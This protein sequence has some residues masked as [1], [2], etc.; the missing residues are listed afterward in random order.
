MLRQ[1]EL[2]LIEITIKQ[3]AG[4]LK[5]I[6]EYLLRLYFWF[7]L[8]PV[9]TVHWLRRRKKQAHG[10]RIPEETTVGSGLNSQLIVR[11]LR[12]IITKKWNMSKLEARHNRF[13][14][15]L[16]DTGDP[17]LLDMS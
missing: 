8:G 3:T 12:E 5:N 14:P 13:F 11:R 2:I 17:E 9:I 6:Q 1:T 7:L 10:G 15:S 4:D 16:T